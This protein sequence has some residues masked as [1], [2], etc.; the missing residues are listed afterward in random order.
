[1]AGGLAQA[2]QRL[3]RGEHAA[4]GAE[5]RH[6]VLAR[7]GAHR[8]VE[9]ALFVRE[10]DVQHD[11]GARRQ[12]GRDLALEAAQ[13]ER[14]DALAQPRGGLARRPSAIGRAVA[15][16]EVLARAEQARVRE[17]ELAPELVEAVLDRR[18]GER[19]AERR[20]RAGTR[21]AR[22]GCPGS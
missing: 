12:L 15:L 17:V 20:R 21:R 18:A 5:A 8:V 4:A 14:P 16:G 22:P 10:L 9:R 13:H 2:Q 1:M 7:R 11:L 3:E 6:D 19:H